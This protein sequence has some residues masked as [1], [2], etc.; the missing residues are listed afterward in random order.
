MR[1]QDV[2]TYHR[3][4]AAGC[5]DAERSSMQGYQMGCE[6][7]FYHAKGWRAMADHHRAMAEAIETALAGGIPSVPPEAVPHSP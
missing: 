2:A 7:A 5:L 4:R 1:L 6:D 3:E